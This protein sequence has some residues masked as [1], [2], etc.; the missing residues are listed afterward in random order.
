VAVDNSEVVL[1]WRSVLARDRRRPAGFILCQPVL[2]QQ[3]PRGPSGFTSS[4]GTVIA[5]S[6]AAMAGSFACGRGARG[7]ALRA[8][9]LCP[10]QI[11]PAVTETETNVVELPWHRPQHNHYSRPICT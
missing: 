10:Q 5:L 8:A 6:R 3:I 1:K 7:F 11:R 9:Y 2:T 4:D